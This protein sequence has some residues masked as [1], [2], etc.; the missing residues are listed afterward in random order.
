VAVLAMENAFESLIAET[1]KLVGQFGPAIRPLVPAIQRVG[2]AGLAIWVAIDG[3]EDGGRL[4]EMGN[5]GGRIGDWYFPLPPGSIV[6]PPTG[7][8]P[9]S[10]PVPLE[11]QLAPSRPP[12]PGPPPIEDYPVPN[13]PNIIGGISILITTVGSYIGQ[14]II[15]ANSPGDSKRQPIGEE[16]AI[17]IGKAVEK[18]LDRE[19]RRLLHE[20]KDKA[21]G[22]RTIDEIM[23]NVIE[24]F[25]LYNEQIPRE[26]KKFFTKL[27]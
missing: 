24:V 19:A 10:P 17:S 20:L 4:E 5:I 18:A 25:D 21:L 22:D 12:I 2:I 3:Y 13:K 7:F 8:E 15:I 9:G 6:K 27:F 16:K 14:A 1:G 26:V 11:G 23:E